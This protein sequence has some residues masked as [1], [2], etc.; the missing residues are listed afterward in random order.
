MIYE[1]ASKAHGP[2]FKV[3]AKYEGQKPI[4]FGIVESKPMIRESSEDGFDS[5]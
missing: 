4:L 1:R 5:P 2:F 3:L